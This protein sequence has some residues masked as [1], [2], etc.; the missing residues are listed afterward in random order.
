MKRLVKYICL[1][2]SLVMVLAVPAQAAEAA[3]PRSSNFFS[4]SSVYLYETSSTTFQAWFEV[5]GVRT[6]DKIGASEI[7]IQRS[8]DNE[9]WTTM[10]TFSMADYS[11]MIC[12][13]TITHSSYVIY[14]GTKGYYYRA[15][16]KLYAED[17]EGTAT[18][19]RYTSSIYLD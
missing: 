5:T 9:N 11:G 12:E 10:K 4:N 6:L 1:I 19:A 7:K 17:E 15:Y 18:W 13:N 8:S 2:L 14:T 16:I 3:T